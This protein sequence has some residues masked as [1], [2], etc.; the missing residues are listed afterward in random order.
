MCIRPIYSVAQLLGLLRSERA[1]S[2]RVELRS[3]NIALAVVFWIRFLTRCVRWCRS[4]RTRTRTRAEQRKQLSIGAVGVVVVVLVAAQVNR[5]LKE[6][7]KRADAQVAAASLRPHKP[8]PNL[9]AHSLA[10]IT[11]TTTTKRI[12]TRMKSP[13]RVDTCLLRD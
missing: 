12:E 8:P 7:A 10:S 5:A 6:M 3:I 1:T 4:R 13:V 2:G 9:W 11:A